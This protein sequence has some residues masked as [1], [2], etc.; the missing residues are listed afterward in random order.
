MGGRGSSSSSASTGFSHPFES[1]YDDFINNYGDEFGDPIMPYSMREYLVDEE[2]N[3]NSV[4]QLY[5]DDYDD[6]Q[7]PDVLSDENFDDYVREHGLNAIYR[8]VKGQESLTADQM[9]ESFKYGDKYYSGSGVYGDGTYFGSYDI[10]IQYA[11][12]R[13]YDGSIMRGALKA[14]AKVINFR[15]LRQ[16][17]IDKYGAGILPINDKISAYARSRG[18]DAIVTVDEGG[19][20]FTNV[21]NRGALVLA[22][23]NRTIKALRRQND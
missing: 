7:K 22:K 11:K 18:Y 5:L 20:V 10:A 15:Q 13:N 3:Y 9:H 17:M 4:F 2:L 23:G 21:L 6:Y 12:N 8:G 16:E 14:N 1:S 19:E